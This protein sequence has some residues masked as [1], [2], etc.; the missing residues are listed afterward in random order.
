MTDSNWI[1]L[2]YGIKN[3]NF[4]GFYDAILEYFYEFFNTTFAIALVRD[5]R[6]ILGYYD[7]RNY[8]SI[9]CLFHKWLFFRRN[10]FYAQ[11]ALNIRLKISITSLNNIKMQNFLQK[12]N[13]VIHL[14]KYSHTHHTNI[15]HSCRLTVLKLNE[16]ISTH[17]II[18]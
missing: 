3:S 11:C 14:P 18:Y 12:L 17:N 10:C 7:K 1:K 4:S 15:L 13:F 6:I 5:S 2:V 8:S 16:I 9:F